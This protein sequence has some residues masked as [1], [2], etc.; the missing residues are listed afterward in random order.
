MLLLFICNL[1]R[2]ILR[3]HMLFIYV[4]IFPSFWYKL[5]LLNRWLLFQ[6]STQIQKFFSFFFFSL[7]SKWKCFVFHNAKREA[8]SKKSEYEI[9]HRTLNEKEIPRIFLHNIHWYRK[10][11]YLHAYSCHPNKIQFIQKECKKFLLIF[12]FYFISFRIFS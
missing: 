10:Y 7:Y 6:F 1:Y 11:L 2:K 12:L 5:W 8:H 3:I 4:S 9:K